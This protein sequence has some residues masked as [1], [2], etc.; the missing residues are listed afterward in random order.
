[1]HMLRYAHAYGIVVVIDLYVRNRRRKRE[2]CVYEALTAHLLLSLGL[3][4]NKVIC[5]TV[6][7]PLPNVHLPN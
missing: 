5:M 1:M 6:L 3:E 4:V 7:V 2:V